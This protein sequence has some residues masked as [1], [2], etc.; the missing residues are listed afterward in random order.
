[1]EAGWIGRPQGALFRRE[2][3]FERC[4]VQKD[5]ARSRSYA[6]GVPA[7]R[8][9]S[10]KFARNT[11]WVHGAREP[12]SEPTCRLPGLRHLSRWRDPT[13]LCSGC[14]R[15]LGGGRRGAGSV[16]PALGVEPASPRKLHFRSE[17]VLE[18]MI[19]LGTMIEAVLVTP[20]R[21]ERIAE[22]VATARGV[23][24]LP[25]VIV[26]DPDVVDAAVGF[27]LHRGAVA[28]ARRPSPLHPS[29][30]LASAQ[31]VVVLCSTSGST[32]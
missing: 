15:G 32:A 13:T 27:A 5:Y 9:H 11:L 1:M 7:A 24:G 14:T 8:H 31:R 21:W 20:S 25:Q 2:P 26:A 12:S 10:T 29:E 6:R 23:D 16:P 18:R 30:A 4:E 17:R 28:I 19:E 22:A 3:P